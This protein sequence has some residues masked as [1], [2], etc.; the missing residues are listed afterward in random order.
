MTQEEKQIRISEIDD[1]IKMLDAEFL[2]WQESRDKV[3]GNNAEVFQQVG[4]NMLKE[5]EYQNK[6]RCLEDE[7]RGL[8][9]VSNA[10]NAYLES[11]KKPG[12]LE[13]SKLDVQQGKAQIDNSLNPL[14]GK[15]V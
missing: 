1:E 12:Q 7:R 13:Q 14:G 9:E 5:I 6:R 11:I 2:K 4:A 3:A 10:V 8:S 15:A